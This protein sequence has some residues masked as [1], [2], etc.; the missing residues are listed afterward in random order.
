MKKNKIASAS[1][2]M[3]FKGY[4]EAEKLPSYDFVHKTA[5]FFATLFY[6][7]YLEFMVIVFA[8][9]NTIF[10]AFYNHSSSDQITPGRTSALP[11]S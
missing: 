3:R 9:Q 2:F 4:S 11:V 5:V 8:A 7:G 10:L 1:V 6:R